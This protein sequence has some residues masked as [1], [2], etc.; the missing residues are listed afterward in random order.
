MNAAVK[1]AHAGETEE[2]PNAVPEAAERNGIN[3]HDGLAIAERFR[4]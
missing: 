3:A 4:V 1:A 2:K